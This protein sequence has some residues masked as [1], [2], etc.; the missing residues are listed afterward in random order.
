MDEHL[1]TIVSLAQSGTTLAAIGAIYGCSGQSIA[2]LLKKHGI[3]IER[4]SSME[5]AFQT[6][7]QQCAPLDAPAYVTQHRFSPSR[8]WRLDIAFPLYFVGVELHGGQWSGGRHNRG[9]GLAADAEKTN[10]AIE[11]GWVILVYTTSMLQDNPAGCIEQVLRVVQHR[12]LI[13]HPATHQ[14][15]VRE[16][17]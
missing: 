12:M 15:L 4:L 2:R 16:A 14:R 5:R 9:D 17:A 10:A 11:A 6:A 13:L 3:V 8:L 7:W 1:D